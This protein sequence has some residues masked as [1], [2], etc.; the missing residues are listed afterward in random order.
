MLNLFQNI[1]SNNIK[2]KQSSP[3]PYPTICITVNLEFAK[4]S[5]INKPKYLKLESDNLK[6]LYWNKIQ[7]KG[8]PNKIVLFYV[9]SKQYLKL[10]TS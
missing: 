6:L 1:K 7:N 8:Q 9:K 5:N 3:E 4:N 2:R 10:S